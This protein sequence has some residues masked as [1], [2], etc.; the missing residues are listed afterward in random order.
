MSALSPRSDLNMSRLMEDTDKILTEKKFLLVLYSFKKS[1]KSKI[2]PAHYLND[3]Y[4]YVLNDN[5]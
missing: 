5:M 1:W 3:W 2:V 4:F